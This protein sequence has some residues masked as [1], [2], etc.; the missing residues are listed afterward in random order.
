MSLLNDD[1]TVV[2]LFMPRVPWEAT[3]HLLESLELHEIVVTLGTQ[4]GPE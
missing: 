4:R 3:N 2:R 1:H